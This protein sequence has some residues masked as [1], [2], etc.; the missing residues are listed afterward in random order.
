MTPEPAQLIVQREGKTVQTISLTMP[1]LTI[2]RTPDNGLPL[3]DPQVSRYHA[4]LQ[5]SAEGAV[6]TDLDSAHG[7]FVDDIR[8]LPHQPHR[9]TASTWFQIGPFLLTYRTAH[10]AAASDA[11][12]LPSV[13]A[14]SD[15]PP[16]DTP[17]HAMPRHAGVST[18]GRSVQTRT[19]GNRP[20]DCSSTPARPTHP[21]LPV[22]GPVSR[23][24]HDLPII[25]HD[26]DLL[27]RYLQIFE[28]LWEPLEQRQDYIDMYF[29]PRTCPASFLDW[30]ARWLDIPLNSHWPESRQRHLLREALDLYRWRGT[31]YGLIRMLEIC[32]GLTPEIGAY[33]GQPFVF[34]I[35]ITA[36]A[37][38]DID[39]SIIEELI[40]T[41]KPAHVGYV[42]EFHTATEDEDEILPA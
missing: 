14:E 29:D 31:R 33:P 21:V 3:I 23:Y 34:Y 10:P 12:E 19:N 11:T 27:G 26:D 2:G 28:T 18:P 5:L 40:Q 4:E 25:F 13:V 37:T 32:T 9:L 15:C 17:V 24:L 30:F 39:R 6:L 38:G 16:Q 36:P 22:S 7:T 20:G 41:H 1:V 8:L 42:L 35:H